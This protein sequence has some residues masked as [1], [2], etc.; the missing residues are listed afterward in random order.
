MESIKL[1][2]IGALKQ[3]VLE[4]RENITELDNVPVDTNLTVGSAHIVFDTYRNYRPQLAISGIVTSFGL[5]RLDA[6]QAAHFE[7]AQSLEAAEG[8]YQ[9]VL[10]DFTDQEISQLILKGYFGEDFHNEASE[11]IGKNFIVHDEMTMIREETDNG[12]VF[13]SP[14]TTPMLTIIPEVDQGFGL[15]DYFLDRTQEQQ[16]QEAAEKDSEKVEEKTMDLEEKMV[17][18]DENI[19]DE[20]DLLRRAMAKRNNDRLKAQDL[21]QTKVEEEIEKVDTERDTLDEEVNGS[22]QDQLLEDIAAAR[23]RIHVQNAREI[24][25]SQYDMGITPQ[26]NSPIGEALAEKEKPKA[27]EV[28]QDEPSL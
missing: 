15:D 9:K 28:A 8:T 17:V 7:G 10:Y 20:D 2:T 5:S 21:R 25:D 3:H 16:I 4:G 13:Y 23:Q 11:L 14:G 27:P 22:D 1:T 24:V 26:F 18:L 6:E 12:P 19:L